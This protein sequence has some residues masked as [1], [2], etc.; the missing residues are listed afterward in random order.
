MSI[1]T[2]LTGLREGDLNDGEEL[3]SVYKLTGGREER[4]RSKPSPGLNLCDGQ[5]YSRWCFQD[6]YITLAY[7]HFTLSH[8]ANILLQGLYGA[9]LP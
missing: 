5:D 1:F 9:G 8:E 6:L 3:E 7:S 4:A 2:P